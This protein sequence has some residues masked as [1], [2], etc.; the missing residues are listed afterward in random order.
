MLGKTWAMGVE[1]SDLDTSR[2]SE[3]SMR[4]EKNIGPFLN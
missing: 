4:I 1:E 2:G 3:N